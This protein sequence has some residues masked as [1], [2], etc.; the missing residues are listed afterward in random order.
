MQGVARSFPETAADEELGWIPMQEANTL[1]SPMGEAYAFGEMYEVGKSNLAA[2]ASAAGEIL[3]EFMPVETG[4]KT[5]IFHAKGE[6][7]N[8]TMTSG[9]DTS[10]ARPDRSGGRPSLRTI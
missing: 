3:F 7:S 8:R 10:V 9:A 4:R 1:F 5:A 2:F 6:S